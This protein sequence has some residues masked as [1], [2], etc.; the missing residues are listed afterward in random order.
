MDLKQL[1]NNV[2][3][4]IQSLDFTR[5]WKGFI[6]LKFALYNDE[7]CCFNGDYIEKTSDFTA[8]RS[9]VYQGEPIAIW[10]VNGPMDE[11]ILAADMVHEMFH[12]FQN[13]NGEHRFPDEMEAPVKYQ[14]HGDAMTLKAEE[15]RLL[16]KL[17]EDFCREDYE[18]L[19][20]CRKYRSI[21]YPYEY[22]YESSVEQIE[23]SATY[24][25]L[26]ALKQLSPEKYQQHLSELLDKLR[27]PAKLFPVRILS[28]EVG[29]LLFLLSKEQG[30]ADFEFF[31]EIPF[32][33]SM[34]DGVTEEELLPVDPAIQGLMD[35]FFSGSRE[36]I[37]QALSEGDLIADHDC[38]LLSANIYDARYVEPYLLSRFFVLYEDENGKHSPSGDF[39]MELEGKDCI[40]KIWRTRFEN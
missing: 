13:Q 34:L 17:M 3:Q 4:R 19:L 11:D 7:L 1:Y 23:G 31:S 14:Y 24:V 15:N 30:L 9:I 10:K 20:R 25:E 32:T 36:D 18:K 26:A 12:A 29:A 16:A 39:V 27:D 6:P 33:S 8:N 22:G 38:R 28:Y 2:N 5:L 21:H 40:R 37:A 35:S